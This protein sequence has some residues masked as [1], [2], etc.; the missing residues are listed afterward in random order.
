[1]VQADAFDKV[2]LDIWCWWAYDESV[3]TNLSSC[4]V[5]LA[6]GVVLVD[7]IDLSP[8]AMDELTGLGEI[9]AVVLTNGNHARS[10]LQFRKRFG[11]PILAHEHAVEALGLPVDGLLGPDSSVGVDLRVVC[12]PGGGPGEIAFY[13]PKGRLHVG[14]ALVNVGSVGFSILPAKYCEDRVVLD[15]SLRQLLALDIDLLTF[16]HGAPLLNGAGEHLAKLLV[17]AQVVG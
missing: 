12:L 14:D 5:A 11:V 10:S 9:A 8:R 13:N 3:R 2:A 1:M 7:P 16:A 6:D 15:A 17:Q 4:A